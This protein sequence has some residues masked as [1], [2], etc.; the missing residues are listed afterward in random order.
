M[1][2][3]EEFELRDALTKAGNQFDGYVT[4]GSLEAQMAIVQ[5]LLNPPE[6]NEA[7]KKAAARYKEQMEPNALELGAAAR[8]AGIVK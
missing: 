5:A 8:K 3:R 6:P 7:A 1:T 4:R 2:P